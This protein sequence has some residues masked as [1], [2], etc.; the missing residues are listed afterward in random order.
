MAGRAAR[1][2]DRR[3]NGAA[4]AGGSQ[5]T[6]KKRGAQRLPSETETGLAPA[7]NPTG[8]QV[9]FLV[10]ASRASGISLESVREALRKTGKNAREP[11]DRVLYL[12]ELIRRCSKQR[13]NLIS[14]IS[15]DPTS[16]HL[17]H[18]IADIRMT[19]DQLWAA[20]VKE[21]K[22][23]L[24][25]D[26]GPHTT[27]NEVV[28]AIQGL[29]VEKEWEDDPATT[30]LLA[31]VLVTT[32]REHYS[33]KGQNAERANLYDELKATGR[34]LFNNEDDFNYDE[35]NRRKDPEDPTRVTRLDQYL[36]QR[37]AR[38]P[39]F[40]RLTHQ[41]LDSTNQAHQYF[42]RERLRRRLG[43]ERELVLPLVYDGVEEAKALALSKYGEQARTSSERVKTEESTRKKL[44]GKYKDLTMND[45]KDLSAARIVAD[46]A[47]GL[48][49]LMLAVEEYYGQ[50]IIEKE[51]MFNRKDKM[52]D[53]YEAIHYI[54]RLDAEHCFEL[55]LKT[56]AALEVNWDH[57]LAYKSDDEQELSPQAV[58]LVRWLQKCRLSY[59]HRAYLD[60][61]SDLRSLTRDGHLVWEPTDSRPV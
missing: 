43:I 14:Q 37:Y 52:L 30:D 9:P 27:L 19:I 49:K 24:N 41:E 44:R 6:T 60:T 8:I 61:P 51:S 2:N 46:D 29:S 33:I 31:M 35:V 50:D 18:L 13:D 40:Y 23:W 12:E 17:P 38:A 48:E 42:A 34:P 56:R 7:R 15:R 10:V 5:R 58:A 59:D 39:A 20:R 28:A 57:G 21:I 55:Q 26:V 45:V 16:A 22:D 54:I 53:G 4:A 3:A 32:G 36:E 47:L 11:H 25:H 1:V